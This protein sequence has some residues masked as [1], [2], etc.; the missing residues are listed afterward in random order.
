LSEQPP[1]LTAI[2]R[3]AAPY[4][5]GTTADASRLGGGT[6]KG[7]YRV[8]GPDSR[9]VIVYRWHPDEDRWPADDE[10]EGKAAASAEGRQRF[11][12]AHR[13]LASIGLRVPAIHAEQVHDAEVEGDLAVV[14]DL[15]DRMLAAV[16]EQGAGERDRMIDGFAVMVQ[17]L[18]SRQR[19][20]PGALGSSDADGPWAAFHEEIVRVAERDLVTAQDHPV[21]RSILSRLRELL[22]DLAQRIRPRERWSLLHGELGPDHVLVPPDG[23]PCMIDIEGMRYG[24]VE[25]EHAYLA[26]R[27]GPWYERFREVDLDPVRLE[28]YTLTHRLSLVAGPMR[29]L[30]EIGPDATFEDIVAHNAACLDDLARTRG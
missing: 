19:S 21:L 23:R 7:V 11:L 25:W 12:A 29:L 15:G 14:E 4:L 27:F 2:A 8:C 3:A 16:L 1:A 6:S 22:A 10:P 17:R 30:G 20:R 13:E 9:S 28:L 26:L 24:D 18:H 5:D